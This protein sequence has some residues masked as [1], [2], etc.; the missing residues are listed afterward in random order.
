MDQQPRTGA[1]TWWGWTP[2]VRV[3]LALL[4][5]AAGIPL[6]VSTMPPRGAPRPL[7]P[8]VLDPNTAPA[9]V[10]GALP[11]LG[12]ARSDAIV[13]ERANGL[14]RSLDDLDRRVRGIGPVTARALA[15]HLRFP[16]APRPAP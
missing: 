8:L 7:E 9:G 5:F 3:V 16:P 10:L 2:A 12:P 6:S 4:V 1:P 11:G 14:Y 13:S 15:P